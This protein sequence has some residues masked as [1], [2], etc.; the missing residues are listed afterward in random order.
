MIATS[1]C[2]HWHAHS[3][4]SWAIEQK[5]TE[6]IEEDEKNNKYNRDEFD[7]VYVAILGYVEHIMYYFDSKLN[8]LWWCAYCVDPCVS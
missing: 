5:L 2:A 6:R 8:S 1:K 4:M 3:W 7:P